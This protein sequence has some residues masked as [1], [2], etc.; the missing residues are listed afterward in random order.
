MGKVS[1][2]KIKHYI[3]K[4][5]FVLTNL[6]NRHTY[7]ILETYE[8]SDDMLSVSADIVMYDRERSCWECWYK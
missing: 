4:E 8:L 1:F 5:S 3:C 2:Y 6:I 7:E